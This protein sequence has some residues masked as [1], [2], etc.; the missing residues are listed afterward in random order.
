MNIIRSE[1]TKKG[2]L[3]ALFLALILLVTLF[4]FKKSETTEAWKKHTLIVMNASEI[5]LSAM[6]D[7]ET[8]QR[9]YLLTG[10]ENYLEPYWLTQK[11]IA[12]RL[13]QLRILT[14]DNPVQQQRLYELAPLVSSKLSELAQ[15]I[16][17]NRNQHRED[18]LKIVSTNVGKN[19]M[20]SIRTQIQNF[21]KAEKQLLASREAEFSVAMKWILFLI[22]FLSALLAITAYS[23]LSLELSRRKALEERFRLSIENVKDYSIIML[24]AGGYVTSWNIGAEQLEGYRANEIIGQHCSKFSLKQDVDQ[25]KPENELRI[26]AMEG[27]FEEEGWRLRKDGSRFIANVIINAIRDD[28]K[29]LHGYVKVTRDITERKQAEMRQSQLLNELTRINEELNNFTYIASHDLKSPLHGIDQLATWI[30]EDLGDQLDSNTQN[31]LRL[32]RN[33]IN[34]LEMLL[35]D[36]LAYS[37]VGRSHEEMVTVNTHDLVRNIFELSDAAKQIHLQAATDMPILHTHKVP[38]E[39]AF[40]NLINNAIKHHDKPQGTIEITARTIAEGFE[41]SVKDDGPGIPMEHQQRVFGMFQTLKPRDEIEGSGMGLAI[42][43][44]AVESV[45]GTVTLESDG[46]HGCTFRFTW[47]ATITF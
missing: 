33:R 1:Q 35:D 45:G 28:K 12:D 31:H 17:L 7:A 2:L 19:T 13:A 9:G 47:P 32:M 38:L 4:L 23:W 15:T 16:E 10:D 21:N 18:A 6:K 30:T 22:I 43:K 46:Q 40:R 41:F 36:L 42:V 26:A 44:K 25:S 11:N 5:F 29:Q 37:R 27:R 24:D 34:R 20:D 14:Q 39:L 3:L 8:G